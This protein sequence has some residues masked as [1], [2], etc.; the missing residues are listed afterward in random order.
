MIGNAVADPIV[1]SHKKTGELRVVVDQVALAATDVDNTNDVILM[2]LIPS[3]ARILDIEVLNDE[4][5][6]NV[7]ATL[8]IDV[9]LAYTGIGSGQVESDKSLGDIID[10]DCFASAA[11]TLQDAHAT[12][13]SIRYEAGDIADARKE[14]WEVAGLSKDPGGLLAIAVSVETV[15]ATG[16][17]GD[18]VMKVSYL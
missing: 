10:A 2:G 4:I 3:N 18:V 8:A 15:A 1:M 12:W 13:T 5:D 17:A 7:A 6:T 9:G 11:T 14:A 16:A